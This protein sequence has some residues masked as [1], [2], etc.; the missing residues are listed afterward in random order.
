MRGI[1]L[2]GGGSKG[3][4]QIGAWQ[5]MR[6]RE[7][8]FQLVTGA[9]IGALNGAMMAQGDFDRARAL[10]RTITI[11]SVMED[12]INLERSIQGMLNQA[13]ELAPFLRRYIR[14]KGADITPLR[15]LLEQVVQEER[16]RHS[17]IGFG[18][19]TVQVPA[20]KGLELP[21]REIP[22]G[23]VREY[24]LASAACFP[25][26][27][28]ARIGGTLYID[29]GYYDNLPI[30]FAFREGAEEVIALDLDADICHRE[31][32]AHPYVTYI[33]PSWDLGSMLLFDRR[34]M[35]A[36]RVL[37]YND[38]RKA[39]GDWFGFRF[40]FSGP[41]PERMYAQEA[42][43]MSRLINRLE[44]GLSRRGEPLPLTRALALHTEKALAPWEQL[45]RSLE[46]GGE[47]LEVDHLRVR[48]V[49]ELAE[50]LRERLLRERGQEALFQ[51]LRSLQHNTDLLAELRREPPIRLLACVSERIPRSTPEELS[52]MAA[53]LPRELAG[54]LGLAAVYGE[55]K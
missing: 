45:L 36:N 21:L 9:S 35:E 2:G 17:G 41:A 46:I 50:R 12:G 43:R 14:Y 47:L 16:L 33:R 3:A 10:W 24:L 40:T 26:F 48:S 20:M 22:Q 28:M 54:S 1:V 7:T 19:V 6:E 8:E 30:A 4:Y 18:L 5:V 11:D 52:W 37:G 38:A 49:K 53:N 31:Y 34:V 51:R 42:G 29:G 15:K 32:Y 39:L 13:G 27:P 23:L 44:A 25:A 55:L